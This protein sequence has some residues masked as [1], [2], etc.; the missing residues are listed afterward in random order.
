M[1][2]FVNNKQKKEGD[3]VIRYKINCIECLKEK[4]YNTTRILREN[5]LSQGAMQ[6][7]RTGEIVGAK[8]LDQLCR[9]LE[10]QPGDILEYVED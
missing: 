2:N 6:K 10:L 1:F 8:V 3:H 4:G 7:F 5:I 9:L